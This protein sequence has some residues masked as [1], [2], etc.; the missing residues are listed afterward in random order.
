M[1]SKEASA[2]QIHSYSHT[3]I[4]Q[5]IDIPFQLNDGNFDI[6]LGWHN[7]VPSLAY[8]VDYSSIQPVHNGDQVAE[9]KS[10]VE[11]EKDV[12]QAIEN[13]L[14]DKEIRIKQIFMEGQ[15]SADT[16]KLNYLYSVQERAESNHEENIQ[17]AQ[18]YVLQAL[19]DARSFFPSTQRIHFEIWVLPIDEQQQENSEYV[20]SS[21]FADLGSLI[22]RRGISVSGGSSCFIICLPKKSFRDY[23]PDS[24][25]GIETNTIKSSFD[26]SL[27]VQIRHEITHG[28]Q[29]TLEGDSDF[30]TEGVAMLVEGLYLNSNFIHGK[31]RREDINVEEI[32][33]LANKR[34]YEGYSSSE[35][36]LYWVSHSLFRF[37]YDYFYRDANKFGELLDL[38]RKPQKLSFSEAF[39]T[40]FQMKFEALVPMW[41]HEI[42]RGEFQIEK[43][44]SE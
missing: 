27:Y 37:I 2:P 40:V 34:D 3:Y 44:E 1:I 24:F 14:K 38:L 7:V 10:Q 33:E 23:I 18:E 6:P 13:D 28:I 41:K 11:R 35:H 5:V 19:D 8:L 21:L 22:K 20:F 15:S 4:P 36:M 32:L 12:R 16:V 31:V 39:Y 43:W 17:N 42:F 26:Q 30:A 9:K 25:S 29:T